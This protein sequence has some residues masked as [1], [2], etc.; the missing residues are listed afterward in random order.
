MML[1]IRV[2]RDLVVEIDELKAKIK[3]LKDKG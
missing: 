1:E 2:E 3:E